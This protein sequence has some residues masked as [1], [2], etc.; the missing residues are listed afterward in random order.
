MN[1]KS[2]CAILGLLGAATL[3][4]QVEILPPETNSAY[5]AEFAKAD[6]A[7]PMKAHFSRLAKK[8][9]EKQK[10]NAVRVAKDFAEIKSPVL[11]YSVPAMSETQYLP[12]AYPFDG[13]AG[14]GFGIISAQK[15]YEPGS[16]VLYATEDM[17]K[18][19]FIV[20]D[21]KSKE[22]NVFPKSALDLKTVKVWYQ[23]SNGWYSYFQDDTF[24]LCPELLLNDEDLIKVDTKEVANYARLTNKD[25]SFTYRWLTPPRAVDN[26]LEDSSGYQE[27]SFLCMKPNFQD[28]ATFKGATLNEGEFKQFFLTAHVTDQKPGLYK[29]A[30]ALTK[31]GKQVGSIPV[32]LRVLPFALPKAKT[33]FDI[34][35]DFLVFF[36]EYI[37]FNLIRSV[38]GNDQKLAERQL[39]AIMKNMVAHNE[40]LPN[41]R[42]LHREDLM[43]EA[44]L[45]FDEYVFTGGMKLVP[46]AEMKFDARRRMASLK[47][48]YPNAK[49]IFSSWGDEYGLGILRGIIPMVEVY[50]KHGYSFVSNSRHSYSGAGYLVD[51]FWPP[52]W[53]DSSYS[54]PVNKL[55]FTTGNQAYFGWYATQHVG[56]ENPAFIRRQYGLGAYRAGFSCHYNYAHHLNGYNDIRGNTYK[57]MNFFY[58]DGKGVIDTLAWEAFREGMDDIRYATLLQQLARPH[59]T[60]TNFENQVAARKAMQLL[61]DMNTDDFDQTTARLEMIRHILTLQKCK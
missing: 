60:S 32:Q 7:A 11:V 53:P 35:K 42:E 45:V 24:K 1:C 14:K 17:G 44:G 29:G 36:C 50:K 54:V 26:R 28:A 16:V 51:L 4:A 59:L 18:L 39:V 38:N 33:F 61:S 22:G 5:L 58:G 40:N 41:H 23:N 31:N 8:G 12:D 47:K 37:S 10:I 2:L 49:K 52:V 19:Q 15:E 43:K 25:G 34:E 21:L 20:S 55:N 57:S 3:S 46:F 13:T 27:G 48:K 56:V 30:I 6:V 9:T